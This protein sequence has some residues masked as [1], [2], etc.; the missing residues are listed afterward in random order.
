MKDPSPWPHIFTIKLQVSLLSLHSRVV[1]DLLRL[2]INP[3]TVY[4]LGMCA[5]LTF[6]QTFE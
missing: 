2:V 1:L 3:F 4:I 6:E 5:V